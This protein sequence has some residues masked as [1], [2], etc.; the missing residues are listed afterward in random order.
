MSLFDRMAAG[1]ETL[2]KK[3]NQAFD[4]GKLR[5]ELVRVRRRMDNAARDLGYLTYRQAKGTAAAPADVEALTRRISDAEAS[6]A[7]LEAEIAQVKQ[8]ASGT[9]GG[10]SAGPSASGSGPAAND[11]ASPAA[12]GEAAPGS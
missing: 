5:V 6:V 11:P 12:P 1:L 3:A 7:R 4:E 8:R 2:G 9:S 10:G